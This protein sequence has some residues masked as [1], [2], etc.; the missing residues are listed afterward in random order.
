[1]SSQDQTYKKL[2]VENHRFDETTFF[3]LLNASDIGLYALDDSVAT[4]GKM[5]MKVLDYAGTGLPILATRYGVSPHL[6]DENNVL[7][8]DSRKDW[9]TNLSKYSEDSVLRRETGLNARKM[10][11]TFHSIDSSYKEFIALFSRF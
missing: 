8:C 1:V 2:N 5:A 7:F 11:E 4:R 6:I 9:L 3:K 10:A